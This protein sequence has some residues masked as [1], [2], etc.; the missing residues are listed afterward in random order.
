MECSIVGDITA[1]NY[2]RTETD[3]NLDRCNVYMK[4]APAF[5]RTINNFTVGVLVQIF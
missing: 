2:F 3:N 5:E 4:R 1:Q